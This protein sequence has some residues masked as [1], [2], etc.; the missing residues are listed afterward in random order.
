MSTKNISHLREHLFNQLDMLC[1]LNKQVDLERSRM[2]CET[3][4]QIIE[5]ARVEI[6]FAQ[7]LKGALTVPFIEDQPGASERPNTP[8]P[9]PALSHQPHDDDD[10]FPVP[11]V[12][13]AERT[14][15][16]LNSGPAADHPWRGLG[17]RRIHTVGR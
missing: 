17:A 12:T 6:E 14:Q 4:K 1:D 2:V 16:A 13:A 15:G 11:P 10:T 8:Q 9:R 5:T 7:V 3:S